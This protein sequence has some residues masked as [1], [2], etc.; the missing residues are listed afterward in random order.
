MNQK[1]IAQ[2]RELTRMTGLL[3][4]VQAHQLKMWT[5]VVLCANEG[6]FEFDPEGLLLV[7]DVS[8]LDYKAMMEG[9][10][11]DIYTH[12]K[13]RM[14]FF[15]QCVKMLIG[16]EYGVVIKMKGNVLSDFPPMSMPKKAHPPVSTEKRSS[17]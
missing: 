5:H 3:N 16:E 11:E 14:A 8:N 6:V 1:E 7:A 9:V 4:N 13:K 17:R 12:F 2:M 15:D 10:S